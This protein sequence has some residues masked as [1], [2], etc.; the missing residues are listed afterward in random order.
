MGR[1]LPRRHGRLRPR[2]GRLRGQGLRLP[3]GHRHQQLVPRLQ[4]AGPGG[5]QGRYTRAAA[6]EPQAAPG[7]VDRD[8]LGRGLRPH[9]PRQGRRGRARPG[10]AGRVR[11][12]RRHARG[13]QPGHA[14]AGQRPAGAPFDRR[15]QAAA[16]RGRLP[17]RA[18]VQDRQAAGA[19]LR[20][21]AHAH[22]GDQGRA[23]LDG[24]AVRQARGAARDPR[25]RLQPV[26][27]QDAQ[28][29]AADLLVGLAGRLP[30]R[31]ELP[32]PA[33]RPEREVPDAGRERGQLQQP[34]IRP[35]LPH[36][37]DAGR[38]PREAEGH[39]PDGGHRARGFALGLGLLALRGAG[40]PAL[41]AQRQAEHPGARPGQVLPHRPGDARGQA[42]R[43]EPP[44]ALAAG[45][46]R[47]GAG[48][49]GGPGLARLPRA[50]AR[51][52]QTEK[53]TGAVAPSTGLERAR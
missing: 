30:R 50:A 48:A 44:G 1:G 42:G 7:P 38:R 28:G 17:E 51:H 29:Q 49:A 45:A 22:A 12:A 10:A 14:Q 16:R 21:P 5:R 23:R 47:P 27:G 52:G 3:A 19:E 33:L 26:P 53:S 35:P 15:R 18:R 41:G 37:A 20:L 36:H 9:L 13:L 11:L 32:V 25:H 43:M 46:D 6:E 39:R 2:Q 24:Q 8:R 31:G 40:L 34:G 4:L